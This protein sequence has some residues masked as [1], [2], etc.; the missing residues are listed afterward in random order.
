MTRRHLAFACEAETLVGTLDEGASGVGLLIVSGGSEVRAGPFGSQSRIAAQIAAHGHAVFRYDRRGIGDSTGEDPR[1]SGSGADIAAALA[2]FR[3]A[4][5]QVRRVVAFGNC[6]AGSAL[7]LTAGAGCDALVLTNPWTFEGEAAEDSAAMPAE[8]IR[9]RYAARLKDPREW[10]RLLR[11]GV[12]LRKLARGLVR[13]LSKPAPPSS[14]AEDMRAG[15]AR[16]AGDTR[17]LLAGSDRTAQAF[18]A[19]W[20][21]DDPR[22]VHRNRADHAFSAPP[23]RDW[24]VAQ[25]LAALGEQALFDKQ[26][27]Q[28]DVN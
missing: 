25:I 17:I 28:L 22:L 18:A 10:L 23:D 9:A 19:V 6:D 21:R 7:M 13:A 15:L 1:F 27:G 16:F 11:G 26:A 4:A 24:L 12:D 20:P 14:L 5:P 2:A 3:E 8:A